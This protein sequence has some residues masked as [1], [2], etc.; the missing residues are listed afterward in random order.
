MEPTPGAEPC[1]EN[2]FPYLDLSELY[3]NLVKTEH[4]YVE[5]L[6]YKNDELIVTL[7]TFIDIECFR[8]QGLRIRGCHNKQS[9]VLKI[10]GEPEALGGDIE[11]KCAE[12]R[13]PANPPYRVLR[14]LEKLGL[15]KI[16]PMAYRIVDIEEVQEIWPLEKDLGSE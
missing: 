11:P 10:I 1:I 8:L 15:K 3:E 16:E 13:I 14:T 9:L 5:F 6:I 7:L 12:A 2:L 4:N